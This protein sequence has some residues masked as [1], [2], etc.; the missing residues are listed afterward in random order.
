MQKRIREITRTTFNLGSRRVE[1][2][3]MRVY[4]GAWL[5]PSITFRVVKIRIDGDS[6]YPRWRH[7]RYVVNS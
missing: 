4:R 6:D 7:N 2:I 1:M 3:I 5:D